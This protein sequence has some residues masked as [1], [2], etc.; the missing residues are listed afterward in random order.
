[1]PCADPVGEDAGLVGLGA[2]MADRANVCGIGVDLVEV[3]RVAALLARHPLASERLFTAAER[4]YCRGCAV[5]TQ[6]YAARFAAKEAVGKALGSGVLAWHEIEVV[7]GGPPRVRLSGRTA[8]LAQRLG[9]ARVDLSL[10]H[11]ATLAAAFAVALAHERSPADPDGA[12]RGG[13][14]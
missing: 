7:E 4:A 6:R 12:R 5:A 8:T 14:T 10:T 3:P 2:A 11:T 13:T 1:M 9:V